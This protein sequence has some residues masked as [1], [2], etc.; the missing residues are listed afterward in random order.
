MCLIL[1]PGHKCKTCASQRCSFVSRPNAHASSSISPLAGRTGLYTQ[2]TVSGESSSSPKVSKVV[3]KEVESKDVDRKGKRK[4]A[5]EPEEAD[6][7]EL[8]LAI[9]K[10]RK[11]EGSLQR[12]LY[13]KV[14]RMCTEAGVDIEDVL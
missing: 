11:A 1:A 5:E 13:I 8:D 12:L 6:L 14:K 3:R 4:A 2:R 10:Y 7:V 9:E